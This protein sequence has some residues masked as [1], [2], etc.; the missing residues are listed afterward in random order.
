[1]RMRISQGRRR[2]TSLSTT[3]ARIMA[4]LAGGDVDAGVLSAAATLATPFGAELA[5]VYA[6][7]DVADLMPWMGEGFMGGVQIAAVESL[8]EAAAEGRA[9][10]KAAFDACVYA[11][12]VFIALD[13][14][15]W[16]SLSMQGR[17][18]DVVVFDGDSAR[19]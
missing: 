14:P 3:W 18:S 5:G 2:M 12:K 10:A 16:S 6:P 7:A 11:K 19:G 17:L 15:V 8:K 4:P 9:G 13:S 1:M